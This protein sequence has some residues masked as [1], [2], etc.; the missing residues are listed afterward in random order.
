MTL[1]DILDTLLP[2]LHD[3]ETAAIVKSDY[4]GDQMIAYVESG[5]VML[6]AA[7]G[8]YACDPTAPK[9]AVNNATRRAL[10]AAREERS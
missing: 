7:Q 8:K 4:A 10:N 3:G 2:P 1:E 5:L 9:D 6:E